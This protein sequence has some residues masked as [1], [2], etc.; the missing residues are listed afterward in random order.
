MI[1][2]HGGDLVAAAASTKTEET[3]AMSGNQ[4]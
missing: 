1:P 2:D 3:F 4:D